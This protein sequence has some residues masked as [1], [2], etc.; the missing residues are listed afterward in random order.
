MDFQSKK[1]LQTIGHK[2][3]GKASYNP[4]EKAKKNFFWRCIVCGEIYFLRS[5][6]VYSCIHS[7]SWKSCKNGKSKTAYCSICGIRIFRPIIEDN[8]ES[9]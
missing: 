8:K 7:M 1:G 5:S 4:I 9:I 6:E 3:C 2:D